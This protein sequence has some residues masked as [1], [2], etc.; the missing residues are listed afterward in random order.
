MPEIQTLLI[1]TSTMLESPT[2]KAVHDSLSVT[3]DKEVDWFV[4]EEFAVLFRQ[5]Q[6]CHLESV[7]HSKNKIL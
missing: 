5:V 2:E 4:Q 7:H 6:V 3:V 1:S